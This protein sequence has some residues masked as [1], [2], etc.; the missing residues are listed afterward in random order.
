MSAQIKVLIV[1]ET[2]LTTATHTKGFDSFVTSSY[3]E[4]YSFLK[5]ALEEGGYSVEVM[6][7][8]TAALTFPDNLEALKA[9][10][11]VV[12][13]DI[14]ANTLLLTPTTWKQ[15]KKTTNRLQLIRDYVEGGGGLVMIGGYLT[16]TGIEAKGFWKDTPVEASLPVRLMATDDRSEH[17]EGVSATVVKADHPLLAGVEGAWP[18][19]L[20]Y[21]R[22]S[23]AEG[24]ELVATVGEDPLLAATTCGAGRTVAFMS[25]CSPHWLPPEFL[26]WAG[27]AP[28]FC[29][30]CGWA[31]GRA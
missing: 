24:A 9:Y 30:I 26:S 20:G 25:D 16:F 19:M 21:N 31:A 6:P 29:N 7:N 13:S 12:L 28:L 22:V 5:R 4:G 3:G 27:Y 18:A 8:E 10:D 17:P 11:V 15:S 2:W 14:G 23:L 1:G